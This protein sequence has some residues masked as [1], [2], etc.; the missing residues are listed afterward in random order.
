MKMWMAYWAGCRHEMAEL[1][2]AHNSKEARKVAWNV[3]SGLDMEG[4]FIQI[5]VNLMKKQDSPHLWA[6]AD[7]DK[8]AKDIAHGSDGPP[9]CDSCFM[10]GAGPGSVIQDNGNCLDCN[11]GKHEDEY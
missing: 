1:I 7:Q 11:E 6:A 8:L 3:L 2:F 4:E 10:W 5:R 9:S